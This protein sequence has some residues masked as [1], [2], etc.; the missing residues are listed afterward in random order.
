MASPSFNSSIN[1][2]NPKLQ[3]NLISS[4]NFNTISIPSSKLNSLNYNNISIS[5][6]YDSM[7]CRCNNNNNGD[8]EVNRRWEMVV[9]DA[10]KGAIK[11]F[12]DYR[13][14][15]FKGDEVNGEEE[16]GEEEEWD[17][18]RWKKHFAE[19]DDQERLVSILKVDL[20]VDV[21]IQC[22]FGTCNVI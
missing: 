12:D 5:R 6:N 13:E 3:P 11:V 22:T 18:E 19:V 14:G 4:F 15:Y 9:W 21:Q 8:G 1:F 7:T 20:L 2:P 16:E 17:W 10:V